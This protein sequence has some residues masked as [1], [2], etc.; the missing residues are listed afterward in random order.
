MF[1]DEMDSFEFW[2]GLNHDPSPI[3]KSLA[4]KS[5]PVLVSATGSQ[6]LPTIIRESGYTGS[7]YAA[8]L[9]SEKSFNSL[10]TDQYKKVMVSSL[11]ESAKEIKF[12]LSVLSAEYENRNL[13]D[14]VDELVQITVLNMRENGVIS[15]VVD[16][17]DIIPDY[18]RDRATKI[19]SH[20]NKA[21]SHAVK[22]EI[23]DTIKYFLMSIAHLKAPNISIDFNDIPEVIDIDKPMWMNLFNN[24]KTIDSR[25]TSLFSFSYSLSG[26]LLRELI[27]RHRVFKLMGTIGVVTET[28]IKVRIYGSV[29]K[30][31]KK[32]DLSIFNIL[33]KG[34][35]FPHFAFYEKSPIATYLQELGHESNF[36]KIVEITRVAHGMIQERFLEPGFNNENPSNIKLSE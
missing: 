21:K 35:T 24:F 20:I 1:T 32:D 14:V 5:G 22:N 3:L 18:L 6:N 30:L 23:Y 17:P 10:N 28:G 7:I 15:F 11:L 13:L 29:H 27:K 2:I 8:S 33:S 16:I 4:F 26:Y 9:D 19:E 34:P 12:P 31:K 25:I 36:E